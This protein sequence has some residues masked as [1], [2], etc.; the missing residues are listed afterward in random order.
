[1]IELLSRTP[2]C[3]VL[4]KKTRITPI[5]FES[6]V[7][8][9]SAIL[10][11]DLYYSFLKT[12]R[13]IHNNLS[14]LH[15][16][17]LVLF[18]IKAWLNLNQERILNPRNVKSRDLNKHKNDV[19]RLSQALNPSEPIYVPEE[20]YHDIQSFINAMDMENF[21]PWQLKIPL[22][23]QYVLDIINEKYR[24]Q[25]QQKIEATYDFSL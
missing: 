6:Y 17:Y 5:P 14:V 19:I 25:K 3:V 8:S 10:L 15:Q 24:L 20:V 4:P 2:D 9:L 12:G 7:K 11:D 16:D 21:E 1:M 22:G 23:K 13:I 18:K